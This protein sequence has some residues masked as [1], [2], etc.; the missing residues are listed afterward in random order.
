M[1]QIFEAPN[2]LIVGAT[3]ANGLPTAFTSFGKHVRLYARG[4]AVRVRAPGGIVMKASGTS[5]SGPMAA[6]AAAA[7][8]AVNPRLS[9]DRVIDGLL[10]TAIAGERAVKLLYPGRAVSWAAAQPR[11][12]RRVAEATSLWRA[13]FQQAVGGEVSSRPGR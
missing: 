2:M 11:A 4:E 10:S 9:T 12:G 13:I 3:G 7:M 1:P 6:R 5:F 8:L